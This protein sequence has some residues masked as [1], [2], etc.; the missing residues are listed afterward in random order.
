MERDDALR[1][2][3]QVIAAGYGCD[4]R[5]TNVT[6]A[7]GAQY[8]VAVNIAGWNDQSKLRTLQQAAGH[9][10][11]PA[12]TL[13]AQHVGMS[14]IARVRV[15]PATAWWAGSR[16]TREGWGGFLRTAVAADPCPS[17]GRPPPRW[18]SGGGS[19]HHGVN[20]TD[21][22]EWQGARTPAQSC[23]PP[24]VFRFQ[25]GQSSC[26]SRLPALARPRLT[27]YPTVNSTM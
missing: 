5:A 17:P 2:F 4:I 19:R 8:T 13:L 1:I 20:A 6:E 23:T 27:M 14:D 3:D 11:R 9:L 25:A 16:P 24:A 21:G 15:V 18:P 26:E 12:G 10:A 22:P 7:S